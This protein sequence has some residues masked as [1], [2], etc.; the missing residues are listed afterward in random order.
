MV[1]QDRWS[2]KPGFT[3]HGNLSRKTAVLPIS[4]KTGGLSLVT[5]SITVHVNVEIPT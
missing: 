4:L 1:F 2:L 5:G 3:V